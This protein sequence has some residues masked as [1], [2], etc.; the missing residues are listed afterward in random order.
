MKTKRILIVGITGSVGLY[1]AFHLKKLGFEVY[2]VGRSEDKTSF[3]KKNNIHYYSIDII[4]QDIF[5]LP[6]IAFDAVLHFA[7]VMP[8]KMEGYHPQQ[9][10]DSVLTGTLNVLNFAKERKIGKIVFTQTRADSNY[11]MGTKTKI[12]ADIVKKFPLTGDHSVYA[13][14]KNAAV[15]LIEH[16]YHEH[17]IKRFVLRLP[18]IYAYHPNKYFY[19]NGVKRVKAYRLLMDKAINSN[20]IEIWGDP[21]KEKEIVYV[22]DL[23]QIIELSIQSRLDGGI[24]NVGRG[25]GISL[26][27]QIK[28]IVDVFSPSENK[29]KISYKPE[30]PDGR[31]FIHDISKTVEEL[32]YKPQY[33]YLKLL[34]DFKYEMGIN[35][36]KTLWGTEDDYK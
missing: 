11:L 34:Q 10:I 31:Q 25:I 21:T 9:Y 33:D 30:K 6:N 19:V 36:F 5:K 18:T 3:F 32:G 16:F 24:Y 26:D 27:E 13:I 29:S 7:G 2:G 28:G 12:Q 1:T 35:R 22:K 17:G 23:V 4:S 14:C 15:D 20:P 8:S